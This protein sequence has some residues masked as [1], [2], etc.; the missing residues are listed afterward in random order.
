VAH[1]DRHGVYLDFYSEPGFDL[2]LKSLEARRSGIRLLNVTKQGTGA[3]ERT[4]ATVY[5]PRE[6]ISYFLRRVSAYANETVPPRGEGEEAKPKNAKLI[7][8][9][10]DVRAAVLESFWQ[11]GG[12]V[13]RRHRRLG[14]GLVEQRG[15]PA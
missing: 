6:K 11:T 4:R 8:S 12:V 5:V 10:A 2:I 9:I 15:P 13:A 14:R 1:A 7:E 3:E